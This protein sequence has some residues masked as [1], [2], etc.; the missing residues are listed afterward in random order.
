M[1][2]F[3]TQVYNW[4]H[5]NQRI[6]PWRETK[7]PYYIWVS[8]VILQQTRIIQG[9]EYFLGFINQ[10]PDIKTLAE[11]EEDEIMRAWQGLGYYTRARNLHFSAKY[12]MKNFKG[13]FPDTYE[14]ILSL[15][16]IGTYSAAAIAS[17][18][19]NLSFPV[20]DGNINRLISRFFGI[21]TPIDSNAGKKEITKITNELIQHK[22]PGFHNQALMEFGALQCVPKSPDCLNCP[23]NQMCYAFN[24]NVVISLPV[25]QN[26]TKQRNRYFTY[27]LFDSGKYIWIEKRSGNDIWKNL[28]QLPLIEEK[29]EIDEQ[30]LLNGNLP[31]PNH[32]KV[33][34]KSVSAIKKHI[35][36]HQI[37]YARVIHIE[38]KESFDAE[39]KFIKV[40]KKDIFKFAFPTLITL[41]FSECGL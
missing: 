9:T 31:F 8:E 3:L 1:D 41:L 34:V 40:E 10:F 18:A 25:K 4:Y 24:N 13:V 5:K 16:G 36:S 20:I 35:L 23:V 21:S 17:I 28:Y 37:I 26:K 11:A 6:L 7:N 14:E 39:M 22:N 12:I 29:E 27:Y 32:E 33:N 15:K 30:N 19:F 2:E 38:V